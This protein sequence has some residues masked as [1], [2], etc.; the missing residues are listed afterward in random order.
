M[1]MR[2]GRRFG[3]LGAEVQ[4]RVSFSKRSEL[5]HCYRILR[6]PSDATVR[7]APKVK[8]GCEHASKSSDDGGA[9]PRHLHFVKRLRALYHTIGLARR[10]QTVFSIPSL[11]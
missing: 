11:N 6:V 8:I 1:A 10:V 4:G 7:S 9:F 3:S 2:A 5:R